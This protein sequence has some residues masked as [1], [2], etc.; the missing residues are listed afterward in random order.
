MRLSSLLLLACIA[1]TAWSQVGGVIA[2]DYTTALGDV[3]PY[4]ISAITT[5][6]SGNTYVVGSRQLNGSFEWFTFAVPQ[7]DFFVSKLDILGNL[8]FTRTFGGK[9]IDTGNAIALDPS[10][11]IYVAGTTTSAD[12]PLTKALQ[13]QSSP[14]GTG[15]I[16]KLTADGSTILYSTYF[17][18]TLGATSISSLATDSKGNLYLTGSTTAIDFPHTAG[19]PFG[20]LPTVGGNSTTGAIIASIS[21]A[22]DK[23]L[24]SGAITGQ[25]SINP[26]TQFNNPVTTGAG[27]AVDSAGNAYVAGNTNT[28]DLPVTAGVI[29]PKGIGA[30]VAKINAAGTGLAYLTYLS[31]AEN[32]SEMSPLI[33]PANV[34]NAISVDAAGNAY[35]GGATSGGFHHS[36]LAL[37]RLPDSPLPGS[38]LRASDL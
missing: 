21:A 24:Y 1:T 38:R 18:G 32:Q 19:M 27:I 23:I 7:T 3:N 34:I 31:A 36:R 11:N 13:T 16:M 6:P 26:F 37:A 8:V 22:G 17:G 29:A 15:F 33:T 35:L 4:K 5:D 28:A 14:A 9:G 25:I 2:G 10:G 20:I 30:F 12:F